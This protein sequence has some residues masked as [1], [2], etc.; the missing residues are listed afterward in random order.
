MLSLVLHIYVSCLKTK[1][2]TKSYDLHTESKKCSPTIENK[3]ISFKRT[4]EFVKVNFCNDFIIDKHVFEKIFIYMIAGISSVLM[5]AGYW[6]VDRSKNNMD[7]KEDM[8]N[9]AKKKKT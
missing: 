4:F 5:L 9:K 1:L 7:I 8:F 6:I 3:I 2:A